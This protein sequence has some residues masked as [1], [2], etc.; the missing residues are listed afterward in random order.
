MNAD[1]IAAAMT[2]SRR[3]LNTTIPG[4]RLLRKDGAVARITGIPFALANGV[5]LERPNPPVSAVTALL[6]EVAAAGV[7]FCFQVRP[8]SDPV[9]A[10]I[11]AERGMRLG[12]EL[13]L[14]AVDVAAWA[15]A[16]G[17]VPGLSVR[18]IGP[19]EAQV[20][21][22]LVSAA[23]GAPEVSPALEVPKERARLDADKLRVDG[24]RCYVGE[25]DGRP[26]ATAIGLTSGEFTEIGSVATVPAFR[27]RGIGSALAAWAVAAGARAGAAWCW[28]QASADGYSIYQRLGFQAIE[29]WSLWES[30]S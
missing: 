4:S 1:R 6:D 29:T 12:R 10:G 25:V 15:R 9:L 5:W 11:A 7:P 22:R 3:L 24:L 23:F 26:V 30:G 14:M 16:A 2:E 13:T 19:D 21:T 8:G 27:H 28:L 17:R 20:H 18:Q